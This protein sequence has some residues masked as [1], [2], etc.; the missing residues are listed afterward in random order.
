LSFDVEAL[1]AREYPWTADGKAIFLNSAS[2]GAMPQRAIDAAIEMTR[3]RT[4]PVLIPD[5]EIFET[6]GKSRALLARLVNCATEEIALMPNTSIGVN[7]AAN[8]LPLRGGDV[9][10]TFEKEFPANVYPWLALR[11]RGIETRFVRCVNGLPDEQQLLEQLDDKRVRGVAVSWV[12]FAHGYRVDL[13]RMGRECRSRGI[14]FV[15]DG[16][17]GLGALSLDLSSLEV[18]VFASGCQKWLL[19]PWGTGFAYVRRELVE[20]IDP[21]EVGW[22]AIQGSENFANFTKYSLE[23]RNDARKFEVGTLALQDFAALNA[24]I[25]LFLE[26]GPDAIAKHVSGLAGSLSDWAS[27]TKGLTLRSP[28]APDQRAGIT[29]IAVP[30]AEKVAAVLREA[31]VGLS[32]RE[33]A[34]RLATHFFNTAGELESVC[35]LIER[36]L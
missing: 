23:F 13:Q 25:G 35:R 28:T 24:T 19:S 9:V 29:T 21:V 10:L 30:D 8:C 20:T 5:A 17:Q 31:G 33:G 3:R 7:L 1:R 16:I 11:R 4:R 15:V 18:D 34:L 26:L 12:G 32:V 2:T 36:T 14:Y 6:L 22:L 27:S